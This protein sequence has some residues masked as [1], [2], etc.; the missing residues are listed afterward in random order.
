MQRLDVDDR[1]NAA[2]LAP[3]EKFMDGSAISLHD[4]RERLRIPLF[5]GSPL[6]RADAGPLHAPA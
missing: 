6:K 1:G 4:A 2:L 3:G 5:T